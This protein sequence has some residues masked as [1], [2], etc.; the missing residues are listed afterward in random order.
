MSQSSRS[1]TPTTYTH[2]QVG[3]LA[4]TRWMVASLVPQDIVPTYTSKVVE[5]RANGRVITTT[6]TADGGIDVFD[7]SYRVVGTTLIVNKP[8][9]II[10]ARFQLAGDQLIISAENFSAVLQRLR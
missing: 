3:P 10:N 8:G 1:S 9:Y 4:N 6:T 7:E 2:T 5:F